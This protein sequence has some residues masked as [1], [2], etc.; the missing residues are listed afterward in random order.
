MLQ[1][2]GRAGRRGLDETGFVLITA[3][4]LRLLDSHPAHLSRNGA[5]DWGALLGLMATAAQQGR[6][7]YRQAVLAQERLFST[8]P[9]VLGVEDALRHPEVPCGLKTD[10]E[11]ARHVRK[12]V[13][14]LLNSRG[15]WEPVRESASRALRVIVAPESGHS[16]LARSGHFSG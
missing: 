14:E 16:P 6:D 8:K 11:R 9:I 15:Q 5:V 3:N 1:M 2:F 13:R 12:H 4:E 7:P 10:S